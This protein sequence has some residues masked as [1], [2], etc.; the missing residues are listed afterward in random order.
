MS[1][2]GVDISDKINIE[3]NPNSDSDTDIEES[4][5]QL[6]E[7]VKYWRSISPLQLERINKRAMA[8]P[9]SQ[10]SSSI[11]Q[12]PPQIQQPLV[13]A[14]PPI[15]KQEYLSMIPDFTGEVAL[16]PRFIEISEKLVNKFYNRVDVNDFQNEYLMS[17][18]LAKVK[19]EAPSI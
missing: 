1:F 3:N 5:K 2:R 8:N 19:G 14:P 17:S 10:A 7:D 15:L 18:I 13:V 12:Q 16:L 6:R 9:N 4:L 11:A